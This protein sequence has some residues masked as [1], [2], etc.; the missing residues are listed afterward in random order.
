MSKVITNLRIK[1][2][3]GALC[4]QLFYALKKFSITVKTKIMTINK[5]NMLTK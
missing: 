4:L 3:N 2:I 1:S 5:N